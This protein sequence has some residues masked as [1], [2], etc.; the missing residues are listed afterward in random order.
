[1]AI[2]SSIALASP[3]LA[4]GSSPIVTTDLAQLRV[5]ERLDV[6]RDGARVAC[7]V[8]ET[9]RD[10]DGGYHDASHLWLVSL[11]S[12][13]GE[14]VQ[15]TTEDRWD[16]QPVFAPD[17][18]SIAFFRQDQG[19]TM[20]VHVVPIGGGEPRALAIVPGGV[21]PEFA[22]RWSPGGRLLLVTAHREELDAGSP[23]AGSVDGSLKD[24]R[25][26]LASNAAG[27]DPVV[28]QVEN[29]PMFIGTS[30]IERIPWVLDAVDPLHAGSARQ[31]DTAGEAFDGVFSLDGASIF[32]TTTVPGTS[33]PGISNRTAIAR[34]QLETGSKEIVAGSENFDLLEPRLS[35][36]GST[37]AMLGRSRHSPFY[38]P[39]RLG[40]VD[41]S[42]IDQQPGWLTG[43]SGFD[44]SVLKYAWRVGQ[45]S[46]ILT[47]HDDG[48]ID[49]LTIS[50]ALLSQPRELLDEK[51]DLPVG[52]TAFASGGGVVAF[53]R[54]AVDSPSG[55]W[56]VDAQGSRLQWNP[57]KWIL[58]RHVSVPVPGWATPRGEDPVPY[59]LYPARNAEPDEDVPLAIWLHPG[60]G[61]MWGP[62]ILE[63]WFGQQ[64]LA[65]RGYAVLQVNPR[66][67][68][69]YG[70]DEFRRSFRD[71]ARG[72]SRDVL[73]A[74]Q[75]VQQK[76]TNIGA[77]GRAILASEYGA[78]AAGWI[79]A[80]TSD[81]GAAVL[82]DGVYQVP[83][84][85]AAHPGWANMVE[86][87]GG[88]PQDPTVANTIRDTDLISHVNRIE[89]PVLLMVGSSGRQ[90]SLLDSVL[91]YR[92]L[93][94]SYRDVELVRYA[95]R[96]GG[97]TIHQQLD[98]Y[99][100]ILV[101]LGTW[102][103]AAPRSP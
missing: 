100:R 60:P 14:P 41:A 45:D 88:L 5:I 63:C 49:L 69:G 1:M 94:L 81:F 37:L 15:L 93:S 96:P 92:M 85:L 21:D 64:L 78:M 54:T 30:S 58:E 101:F 76:Q 18:R 91:L 82:E 67:S 53:V 98:R 57:N 23:D 17:G 25:Q 74:M 71:I 2:L 20:Q 97:P 8:H 103:E 26:W 33:E 6:S 52:V 7:E 86:M 38:E 55:L 99:D 35:G 73:W 56:L 75:E 90:T 84:H 51:S 47:A 68:L 62:G 16:I 59:W 24:I 72:P 61:S 87:L 80:S 44:R 19:G 4:A 95:R 89:A 32:C 102:L 79:L 42:A 48:G 34:I 27:G 77:T 22:P 13:D 83:A 11:L 28:E 36:D 66:G 31:L 50:R 46:L 9:R 39:A 65:S 70:R 3:S 29:D 40:L 12:K 43:P 10:A